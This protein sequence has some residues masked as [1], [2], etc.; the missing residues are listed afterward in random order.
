MRKNDA[1]PR[2]SVRRPSNRNS[3]LETEI[4]YR[5]IRCETFAYLHPARPRCPSR[6]KMPNAK[7]AVRI[8]VTL[9]AVQKKLSLVG[10]SRLV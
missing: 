3:H 5:I 4:S 10:S 2:R 8:V 1:K 7:K 6:W 9:K